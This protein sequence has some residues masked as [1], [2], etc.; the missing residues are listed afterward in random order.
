MKPANG[1]DGCPVWDAL[2][3]SYE[4]GQRVTNF[5]SAL[6]ADVITFQTFDDDQE[7][8]RG[9]LAR[10]LS[11]TFAECV[12][13]LLELNEKGAGVFWTVNQQ[14]DPTKRS[15]ANTCSVRAFFVDFDGAPIEQVY[16]F[17]YQPTAVVESS[18]ERYHAYWLAKD[19]PLED[20]SRIQAALADH[21]GGDPV[22]KDL[23][24]VLRVPYFCHQ[25]NG[26]EIVQ[27][28]DLHPE[29]QYTYTDFLELFP[30]PA[31]KPPNP[32]SY[33]AKAVSSNPEKYAEA[34]LTGEYNLVAS[35]TIG[36]RNHQLNKS[37]FALGQ[38]IG[39]GQLEETDVRHAL[40]NAAAACGLEQ[41]EAQAA[42][43]SGLTAG[44]LKPREIPAMQQRT[45]STVIMF[46]GRVLL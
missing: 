5:F 29:N 9:D 30:K 14:A 10:I 44:K 6:G 17:P 15:N 46:S 2:S 27:L 39:A 42:I 1:L 13:T 23:V 26:C 4:V 36:S 37:A 7:R 20:F 31:P 16:S 19:V 21:F 41:R 24:R 8:K 34:A 38:L 40:E 28:V 43:D 35:C 12:D 18:P 22:V 32:V 3:L 25:K 33:T 11:G 45:Y